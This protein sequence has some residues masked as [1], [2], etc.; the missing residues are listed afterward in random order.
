LNLRQNKLVR[1]CATWRK[2]LPDLKID[3]STVPAW[4]P[5]AEQLA[6]CMLDAHEAA[7]GD[8]RNYGTVGGEEDDDDDAEVEGGGEEEHFGALEALERADVYRNND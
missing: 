4:G 6:M 2:D 3:M 1:L 8:D 5:S 7:R